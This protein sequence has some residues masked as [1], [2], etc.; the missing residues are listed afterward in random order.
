MDINKGVTIMNRL[1]EL[2]KRHR[3]AEGV[4]LL[5]GGR[6]S[7]IYPEKF[8]AIAQKHGFPKYKTFSADDE[9]VVSEVEGF[10]EMDTMV[11][12]AAYKETIDIYLERQPRTTSGASP[13][14][15]AGT[16]WAQCDQFTFK[17]MLETHVKYAGNRTF[18]SYNASKY[19]IGCLRCRT[20]K[21]LGACANCGDQEYQ[22]G[23][24]TDR[25]VGLFCLGCRRGFTS[26]KC[27]CGCVNP[28][29]H[30]TL[31]VARDPKSGRCYIVTAASGDVNSPEV[32]YLSNFRDD[33]LIRHGLGRLFV[34]CYYR[35]SPVLAEVIA[36]FRLLRVVTLEGF[37]RPLIR[38][39]RTM[40]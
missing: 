37:V 27:S 22:L 8:V 23:L 38:I 10:L 36:R 3:D 5:V 18:P 11:V 2:R 25:V 30:E 26:R 34:G 17:S 12:V 19:G 1:E 20:V 31:F 16:E 14:A 40:R 6:D 9:A 39:L 21:P 15:Q 32:L 28:I 4:E 29:S 13:S 33:V 35:V 24:D 7:Y